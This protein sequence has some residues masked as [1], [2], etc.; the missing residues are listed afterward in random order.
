MI[1][2]SRV[3]YVQNYDYDLYRCDGYWFYVDDGYWY[4]AS[5]W[6][7]PF[8]QVRVSSVPRSLVSVPLKYRHHWR[9]VT[10]SNATYYRSRDRARGHGNHGWDDRGH[11]RGR[12]DW[13]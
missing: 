6:R 13:D 8:V 10:Y 11:G 7:G 2:D 5:S 4:R 12:K 9:G 1:P 3:Y